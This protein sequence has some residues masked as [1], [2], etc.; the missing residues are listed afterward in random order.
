[1]SR[2]LFGCCLPSSHGIAQSRCRPPLPCWQG[3]GARPRQVIPPGAVFSARRR[4][5]APARPVVYLLAHRQAV[6]A[7]IVGSAI[8]GA[9]NLIDP[10]S[11]SR[12]PT[13]TPSSPAWQP[14]RRVSAGPAWRTHA[15]CSSYAK[16]AISVSRMGSIVRGVAAGTCTDGGDSSAENVTAVA[17]AAARSAISPIHR[18]HTASGSDTGQLI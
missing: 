2:V 17:H 15:N 7:G 18:S 12:A 1:M 16:C 10:S 6:F 8:V 9:A 5:A 11:Y 4:R 14:G 13:L 3:F